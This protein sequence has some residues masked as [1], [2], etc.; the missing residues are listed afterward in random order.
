[1]DRRPDAADRRA[2]VVAAT[3]EGLALL[4]KAQEAARTA[5]LSAH[6]GLDADERRVLT[7]LLRRIA[8]PD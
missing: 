7:E 4:T 8:F 3:S 1:V 2:N 5:E 6:S